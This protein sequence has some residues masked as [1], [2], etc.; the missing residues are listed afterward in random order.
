MSKIKIVFLLGAFD[1]GGTERQ[2]LETIRRLDRSRFEIKV[3][4]FR[5]YGSVRKK[6]E[7]LHVPLTCLDFQNTRGQLHPVSYIRLFHLNWKIV[8]Y[9]QQEK[10]HI[11]QSYL[12]W[13]NIHGCI[14]AKIA[15][16]PV[17]I[18]G[19]RATMAPE[20]MKFRDYTRRHYR[21]LQNVTNR[22]VTMIVANSHIVKQHCL[23][24]EKFV[25]NEKV[26]VIY[27]GIDVSNYTIGNDTG[28]KRKELHLPDDV[29][30]VGVVAS[31]HPRKGHRD[32][33]HAAKIVLQTHPRTRFLVVGR[34][35]G[36]RS[37][38]EAFVEELGIRSSVVFTGER[39]DIPELLPL[40]DVQVSPSYIEGLSN[41]ILE[42][43]ASGN[44]IVA[45]AAG[46][47][48][49]LVIHEQTGLLIPTEAPKKLSEA[50]IRLLKNP[51]LRTQLGTAGRQR[52]EQLFDM[53][54]MI[55]QTEDLYLELTGNYVEKM[56]L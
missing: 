23:Q 7:A 3:L 44:A 39:D 26:R 51:A 55:R 19:R 33:L 40:F 37:Q 45:T 20:Y 56:F 42:G 29:A 10:P 52:V 50:I 34:D 2:F 41:A 15:G 27:N 53:Q 11:V 13:P 28:L 54:H 36:M 14:A 5:S 9:L 43:M 31:L 49:E 47:N 16:V 4:S 48:S 46:G 6:L 24:R 25:T 1:M 8:R 30:I 35:D 12:F 32:F 22:W 38:L 17:I 21:W 18:T